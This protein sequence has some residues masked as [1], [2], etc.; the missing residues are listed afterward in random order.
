MGLYSSKV[1]SVPE[2]CDNRLKYHGRGRIK[3]LQFFLETFVPFMQDVAS[4]KEF[5][6]EQLLELPYARYLEGRLNHA[7]RIPEVTS[8]GRRRV[9]NKMQDAIA[10][11][12]DIQQYG[13]KSPIDMIE[14]GKDGYVLMRGGRRLVILNILEYKT[15]VAK[16]YKNRDVFIKFQSFPFWKAGYNGTTINDL[17]A[18]QFAKLGV[19]ATDKYRLH[20]Y[21]PLYDRHIGY[22]RNEKNVKILELGVAEGAS[23][24]L[25]QEAF[26]KAS[27]FGVDKNTAIWQRLL[28]KRKRIK[29]F[30]GRE[31]N[32]ELMQTVI[33]NG[34]YN[35]VIDDASHKP[36]LQK[37]AFDTLWPITK[38][39][40]VI[41]DICSR[42]YLRRLGK[43][44]DRITNVTKKLIDDIYIGKQVK[45]ISYYYNICFLEKLA[46]A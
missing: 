42:N 26:P 6:K 37:L 2:L 24:L 36:K 10:L 17:G 44:V 3:Q 35:V 46:G 13:L 27:I 43:G 12:Y 18:N 34:P 28:K 19:K 5:T 45:S 41:E 14:N 1:F 30:V 23:L 20:H 8:K 7:D 32:E 9:L 11:F 38:N 33:D 21:L 39:V 22:L 31:E 25:W 4:G 16:I 29:V 15:V 40:Y